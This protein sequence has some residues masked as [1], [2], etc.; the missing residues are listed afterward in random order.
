MDDDSNTGQRSTGMVTYQERA[1][2]DGLEREIFQLVSKMATPEQWADWLRAPLE[3]AAAQGNLGLVD[4][5][6][7]AGANGKAGWK[8]CGGR[9]FLHAAAAGG[10]EDVLSSLLRAGA[11]P[12]VN[13][14]SRGPP[15][16]SALYLAADLGREAVARRLIMAGAD[17]NF[18]SADTRYTV[19]HRAI[20]GGHERLAEEFIMCG[21][22]VRVQTP[23]GATPLHL[24]VSKGLPGVV[25]AVLLK[26]A[27]KDA[28][29]N[30]GNSALMW[31]CGAHNDAEPKLAIVEM[32][33]AA[34]VDVNIRQPS[35]G[36]YSGGLASSDGH[37]ALDFASERGYVSILRALIR[38]GVD[39]DARDDHCS[40]LH[41]AAWR[42]QAGAVDVLIESGADIELKSHS[43]F[44]PLGTAAA[45]GKAKSSLALL[46]HGA[47]I[48]AQAFNGDTPM[49]LA[50][51]FK[52]EGLE[53]VVDML[54]RWG[55][56]ETAV[57]KDGKTPEAAL[58]VWLDQQE[59][60]QDEVNRV[61]LLL[62]RAPA[63]RA[64]RRRGWLLMLRARGSR[65]RS[66]SSDTSSGIAGLEGLSSSHGGADEGRNVARGDYA[67]GAANGEQGRDV[68]LEVGGS[69]AEIGGG[70]SEALRG[71]VKWLVEMEP[72]GVLRT[73]LEFL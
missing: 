36:Y 66:D 28:V 27:D 42:D 58:N 65:A 54:L 51:M 9:T 31:A 21:A 17:V 62:G 14:L 69:G 33:L 47:S 26:G 41:L 43:G 5:L 34:G 56:D 16:R 23:R 4:K 37:S 73:V 11:Q 61:R 22:D 6:I 12:D 39:V 3:H 30:L 71:A 46:R 1:S 67:S 72:A 70:G 50:C 52:S 55:A 44:T 2:L 57:A 48:G 59:C 13:V 38:C 25:S 20:G 49:H 60:S 15:E 19:L 45:N 64:W 18:R 7:G 8:G 24:A 68:R 53:V 29:D 32:L 10:N 35:N 63:D 40:A